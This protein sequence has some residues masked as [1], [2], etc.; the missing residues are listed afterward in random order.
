MLRKIEEFSADQFKR[1]L[2]IEK[3]EKN[4][5]K[6]REKIKVL[7]FKEDLLFVV[8]LWILVDDLWQY[9]KESLQMIQ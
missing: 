8:D 9:L 4:L 3:N 2:R 1:N 7:T 5:G 6:M